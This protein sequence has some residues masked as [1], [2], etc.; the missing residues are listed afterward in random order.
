[1]DF[2][3]KDIIDV[4]KDYLD[5]EMGTMVEQIIMRRAMNKIE[6]LIQERDAAISKISNASNMLINWGGFY[7]PHLSTGDDSGLAD[8]VENA[9]EV[10]NDRTWT[11]DEA[12]LVEQETKDPIE[13]DAEG[14]LLTMPLESWEDFGIRWKGMT[15]AEVGDVMEG[16]SQ[17]ERSCGRLLIAEALDEAAARL[18]KSETGKNRL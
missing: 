9:F 1:M 12:S 15:D 17:E 4:M 13:L 3:E 7:D 11:T 14:K 8:I 2:P 16:I 6:S 5:H 10:L 18:K